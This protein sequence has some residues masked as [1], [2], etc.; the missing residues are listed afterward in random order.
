MNKP[1]PKVALVH[2][3]L[4]GMRGGEKVLE[5]LCQ[6]FPKAEIFTLVYVKGNLTP[7]IE[8]MKIHTS[9]LQ[10]IPD[11]KSHYRQT[12]PLM[13]W[14][15]R[16]F[17]LSDYD[18]VVSSSHC[19]AKGIR[20]AQNTTHICYCHT[21]MRYIWDQFDDYFG[22]GRC[23]PITRQLMKTLRPWLQT[24][25]KKTSEGVTHFIAN[26]ENVRK[27]IQRHY[28]R[29]STVI[30]PPIDTSFFSLNGQARKDYFLMVTAFAPYKR[31][32]IAVEAFNRLKLPLL[33]AGTGPEYS[34]LSRK[35][36]PHIRFLGWVSNGSLKSLYQEACALIFPGEE[37]LGMVPLEAQ[38]CGCPVLAFAK[39]GALETVVEGQTGL[40]FQESTPESLTEC[41]QR[42]RP[43]DFEA[44]KI[45]NHSLRFNSE[46][47][48]QK[49]I[50]YCHNHLP[51]YV[52]E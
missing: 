50:G 46:I 2:D 12:L 16:R 37:D 40:F 24:W 36:N 22:P 10:R 25:D 29:E 42:F 48:R 19:V 18:L 13:P 47:F 8:A 28:G 49:F 1:F 27:R 6:I 44:S 5:S 3:W 43:K 15:M 26:S 30:Y 7:R 52:F 9:P 34:S 51:Q 20:T 35:A 32:E 39:G 14:A 45:R 17:D 11:I 21:P 23:S 4:T 38:A 41:L 33:I 31:I